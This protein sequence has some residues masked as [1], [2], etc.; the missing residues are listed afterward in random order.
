VNGAPVGYA[1]WPLFGGPH[2]EAERG[3]GRLRLRH[4]DRSHLLDFDTG[5]VEKRVLE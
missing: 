1:S 3:S 2:L 4:G 5:T